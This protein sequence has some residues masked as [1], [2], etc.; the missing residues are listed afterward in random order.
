MSL[1]AAGFVLCTAMGAIELTSFN[2]GGGSIAIAFDG[3]LGDWKRDNGEVK[4]Q[5]SDGREFKGKEEFIADLS[6][7]YVCGEF[8]T[9]PP[10]YKID[11][12]HQPVT[13]TDSS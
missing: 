3:T 5:L 2:L 11:I 8:G 1:T 12:E 10:L 7:P 6:K 13:S 9:F 4:V